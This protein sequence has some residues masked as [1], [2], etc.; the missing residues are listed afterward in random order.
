[1]QTSI[2]PELLFR[3]CVS[4][5][6]KLFSLD[7]AGRRKCRR[8]VT[9]VA[10][11]RGEGRCSA[12]GRITRVASS[13]NEDG[14][15]TANAANETSAVNRRQAEQRRSAHLSTTLAVVGRPRARG[16]SAPGRESEQASGYS[17]PAQRGDTRKKESPI[18][19]SR[20]GCNIRTEP[21][22]LRHGEQRG[23]G[24]D[25]H[26]RIG[27]LLNAKIWTSVFGHRR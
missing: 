16:A 2:Q 25:S 6:T 9:A 14:R 13:A 12:G 19:E 27:R 10:R 24:S 7:Q 8:P 3:N 18:T 22:E 4:L 17:A 5:E 15:P 11:L 23:P 21:H 20:E 26:N 1:M